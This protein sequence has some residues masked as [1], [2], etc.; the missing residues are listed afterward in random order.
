MKNLNFL[1]TFEMYNPNEEEQNKSS[2]E[3]DQRLVTQLYYRLDSDIRNIHDSIYAI[4]DLFHE[5]NKEAS[6]H[7]EDKEDMLDMIRRELDKL[8]VDSRE[9]DYTD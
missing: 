9:Y 3:Y 5:I 8:G 4:I 1:K 6:I 7:P 2:E